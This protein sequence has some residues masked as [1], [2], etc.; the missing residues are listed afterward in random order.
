[1]EYFKK[2]Y[3]KEIVAVEGGDQLKCDEPYYVLAV[4]VGVNTC[5]DGQHMP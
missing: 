4:K 1:M 3:P 5:K 2:N